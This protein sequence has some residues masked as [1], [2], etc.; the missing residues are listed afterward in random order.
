MHRYISLKR[1][2]IS[3]SVCALACIAFF[4]PAAPARAIYVMYFEAQPP[5]V[6]SGQS[7]LLRFYC[8]GQD[9][10]K[11][12]QDGILVKSGGSEDVYYTTNPLYSNTTFAGECHDNTFW[13]YDTAWTQ[14][15]VV[16]IATPPA[17]SNDITVDCGGTNELGCP[18]GTYNNSGQVTKPTSGTKYLTVRAGSHAQTGDAIVATGMVQLPGNGSSAG[19][20]NPDNYPYSPGSYSNA[21]VYRGSTAG[22]DYTM[23]ITASTP[24]GVYY[25][26]PVTATNYYAWNNYPATSGG[27]QRVASINVVEPVV[28][29]TVSV[30]ASGN[31]G[32]PS[33]TGTYTISRTGS[34]AS[35][36]SV[37]ASISGA[38]TRCTVTPISSCATTTDYLLSG[39]SI[40]GTGSSVT[41]SI[42][43]GSASCAVTLTPKDN[44]TAESTE[45]A[46][47]TL[48]SSSSYTLSTAAATLNISDNDSAMTC[49]GASNGG[50]TGTYPSCTC[51]NTGTYTSSTN[52]C[53]NPNCSTA[54]GGGATGTYPNC[55]CNT[56]GSTYSSSNHTCTPAAGATF[57]I[58]SNDPSIAK[59]SAGSLTVTAIRN[60][61]SSGSLSSPLVFWDSGSAPYGVTEGGFSPGSCTPGT[62]WSTCTSETLT[63]SPSA[64]AGVYG[65]TAYIFDGSS[66]KTAPFTLT[67][68][69]SSSFS[70][71]LS[72]GSYTVNAMPGETVINTIGAYALSGSGTV[73][74]FYPTGLPAGSSYSFSPSSCTATNS[75][76]TDMTINVPADA[77]VGSYDVVVYADGTGGVQGSGSFT[78]QV[79]GGAGGGALTVDVA[80][81]NDAHEPGTG[82]TDG[83]RFVFTRTGGEYGVDYPQP[84]YYEITGTATQD[85]D[86][87]LSGTCGS[88]SSGGATIPIGSASCYIDV[89]VLDDSLEESPE[90][91]TITLLPFVMV[92]N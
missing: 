49:A 79:G 80:V 13:G 4:A 37:N 75:A 47:M 66:Y 36:L 7:T 74:G 85:S 67:I 53:G 38:A 19:N 23:A 21:Q 44:T 72:P 90:T 17:P 25:F 61:G 34:T 43:S 39:C 56:S 12:Y 6:Y 30:I 42:P 76:C 50:A 18:G 77:A 87:S 40:S 46:T 65:G 58:D 31:P 88:I 8:S 14:N 26:Y 1:H 15:L 92:N 71:T 62:S 41:L 54:S 32:E 11:I 60:S 28:L 82:P 20:V 81:D 64:T 29:P 3:V 68:Q 63:I 78:L 91:I 24:A 33:T 10:Y 69:N 22:Y 48:T 86:Y 70:F 57:S 2:F 45:D 16:S 55:S 27:W 51:N 35:A 84:M 9:G 52:T 83:G 89:A 73:S 59:G 5:A